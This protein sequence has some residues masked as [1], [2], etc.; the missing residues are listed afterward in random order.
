MNPDT[1]LSVTFIHLLV[2]IND[3]HFV[4]YVAHGGESGTS[5]RFI[6]SSY[7]S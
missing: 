2:V 3:I 7:I 6:N 1:K 4:N 5:N